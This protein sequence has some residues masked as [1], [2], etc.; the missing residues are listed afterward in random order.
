M[1][2]RGRTI[3]FA[4]P[5][6]G[7]KCLEH[8][9]PDPRPDELLIRVTHA[10][11]CGTDAHR[12]TGDLSPPPAPICFGHEGVGVV[13]ALGAEIVR[14]RAGVPLAEGDRV[15]WS[16]PTP[17]GRCRA[18]RAG[19]TTALCARMVWPPPFGPAT[20]A[21]FQDYATVRGTAAFYRVPDGVTSESVIAFGCAMPTALGGLARLG[22]V[23]GAFVVIQGSGPVGLATCVA[24]LDAGAEAIAMIGDP[25]ARLA[26]ARRLGATETLPLAATTVEERRTRIL[27]LTDGL[28]PPVVVEAAGH[29]T[30]FDEGLGL[31]AVGG[32][33][34][35][36]GLYSG[37]ATTPI[38]PV[39][40]NNR[41]LTV[42]GSLGGPLGAYQRAVE[43]AGRCGDA[44]G[45][46]ALV[47]DRFPLEQTALAIDRAQSGGAMKVVVT[48]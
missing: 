24:A 3:A 9:V 10:G 46:D 38:N 35:V 32:R 8:D 25:P 26:V 7:L 21:S 40:I 6:Q 44:L 14:D 16:P 31:L 11:V 28:G 33:Y 42:L 39:L 27:E 29:I 19:E 18:C 2:R 36:L 12:L 1:R 5:G 45:F 41:Q 34:L 17:C 4:G 48:P 13:E 30:A 15:T 20:S 47:T 43:L 22:E 23:R 37:S